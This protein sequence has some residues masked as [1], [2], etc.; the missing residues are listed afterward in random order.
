MEQKEILENNKL[1]AE[2]MGGIKR[3]KREE[4]DPIYIFTN[5][6]F[7]KADLE[8]DYMGESYLEHDYNCNYCYLSEMKFNFSWD[9]LMPVVEKIEIIAHPSGPFRVLETSY[10][11]ILLNTRLKDTYCNVVKFIK[12]YT[13]SE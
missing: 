10:N 4:V 5:F 7:Y 8:P 13:E 3:D 12:W 11:S 6:T 1:I 2:F 9:W